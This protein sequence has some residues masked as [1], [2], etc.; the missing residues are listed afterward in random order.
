MSKEADKRK[1]RRA[2]KKGT[3]LDRDL[4]LKKLWDNRKDAVY[5][6]L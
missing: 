2:L 3:Y 1:I 6:R 5:D 4:V